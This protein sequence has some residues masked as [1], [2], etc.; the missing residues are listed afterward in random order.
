MRRYTTVSIRNLYLA[1]AI[2]AAL[3]PV[4]VER[5]PRKDR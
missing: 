3:V 2:A 5:H 4:D 1:A